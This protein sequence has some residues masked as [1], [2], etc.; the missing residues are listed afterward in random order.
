MPWVPKES[1]G[2]PKEL[3]RGAQGIARGYPRNWQGVPKELPGV[4]KEL[5]RGAQG[6]AKGYPS[7]MAGLLGRRV[8]VGG[9]CCLGLHSHPDPHPGRFPPLSKLRG[10]KIVSQK[11]GPKKV[12]ESPRH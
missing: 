10:P 8:E 12:S 9:S 7:T 11:K 3:P 6:I 2:V 1:P 4:P 5:P